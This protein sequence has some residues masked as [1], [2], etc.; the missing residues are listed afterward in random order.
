MRGRTAIILP[1]YNMP[2][3]ADALIQY[4]I[5]HTESPFDL[6]VIDNGSDMVP[7]AR[8]TTIWQKPNC[9]TVCAWLRGLAESDIE[10]AKRGEPYFA[11]WIM[12]TSAEFV[13]GSG[14][15]LTPIIDFFHANPDAVAMHAALTTDSGSAHR[16]M[17][18]NR[19]TGQPRRTFMIDNIA[20]IWRASY[21][22][23]IGRYRPEITMGWGVEMEACWKAR[24]D[25]KTI[26]IHEG[27]L[28]KKIQDIGYIKNR[29]GMTGADRA[30]LASAEARRVFVPIYGEDFLEK[31]GH[32]FTHYDHR[33]REWVCNE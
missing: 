18:F 12:T 16:D 6:F 33:L 23:R 19:G 25:G 21:L 9:Q 31:L 29:M 13:E 24:R 8:Y 32:E 7:P 17:M 2:W 1:N 3:R 15:P 4:I 11:Y 22:N 30:R 28:I 10:A 14:D 5:D 27:T 26:W 20:S